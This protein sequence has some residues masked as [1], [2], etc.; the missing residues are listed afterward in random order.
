VRILQHRLTNSGILLGSRYYNKNGDDSMTAYVPAEVIADSVSGEGIRLCTLK[1]RYW[2]PIHSELMTHRVFSRNARSSRAVP[3]DTLL[4]EPIYIPHMMQNRPGMQALEDLDDA[5]R[6]DAE[7]LWEAHAHY[8]RNVVRR[9]H[10][11][12][13]HKQWANRPLEWFGWIDVLVTSTDWANWFALR[14]HPDAMPEI[15]ELAQAMREAMDASEPVSRLYREGDPSSWHLPYITDEERNSIP[16][17][18]LPKVSTARCARISYKPFDEDNVNVE[19]D[20]ELY[21]RLLGSSPV[22]ASPAE[23]QAL[24]DSWHRGDFEGY[25]ARWNHPSEHGNFT[26]WRQFRKMLPNEAV[27]DGHR[28]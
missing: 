27:F 14:D 13:V 5:T 12:G 1:L 23:H 19:K 2:R 15:R 3:V 24:P 6:V 4:Q 18:H 22:H 21:Q 11:L 10:E 17:F 16:L 28:R 8:T 7:K 26:G 20:L 25:G 9:L